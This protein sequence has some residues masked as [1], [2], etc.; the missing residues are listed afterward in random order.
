M[1]Q[2]QVMAATLIYKAIYQ[3]YSLKQIMHSEHTSAQVRAWVYETCRWAPRLQTWLS[4]LCDRPMPA[5]LKPIEALCLL[6]LY[7]CA[8]TD[9]PVA[10][11]THQTVEACHALK[12]PKCKP[13]VN[14][15]LRRFLREQASFFAMLNTQ[16]VAY[17]S[18]P[19]PFIQYVKKD[20]P[21]DWQKILLA[22]NQSS[23]VHLRVRLPQQR[24]DLIHQ[25]TQSGITCEAITKIPSA[26]CLAPQT[27]LAN[28]P[29]SQTWCIQDAGAQYLQTLLPRLTA[30]NV[31]DIGAAPGGKTALLADY[32]QAASIVAADVSSKRCTQ[33][34]Q[35]LQDWQLTQR[36]Q[37]VCADL[38]RPFSKQLFDLVVLD[39]PCSGSGIISRQP[40][41]KYHIT[42]KHLKYCRKKQR[43]LLRSAWQQVKPGGYL[44][45]IT[46]SILKS[47]GDQQIKWFA[48]ESKMDIRPMPKA[49]ECTI[50]QHGGYLLPNNWH[51]GFYYAL[52]QKPC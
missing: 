20:W 25:L 51:N 9:L 13:L 28:L 48:Q 45:Y 27:D 49:S 10:V 7:L 15:I 32:Y 42:V 6:G 33:L 47:E 4:V 21:Q 24:S 23:A 40:D 38:T 8:F 39:A 5:A 16:E 46:C 30:P 35:N 26:I 43:Q 1:A 44:I 34:Q 14:A 12:H 37:V 36:V 11:S 31:L 41:I 29:Q 18:H 52:M 22:N 50:A 17:Y 2:P 3:R 19:A